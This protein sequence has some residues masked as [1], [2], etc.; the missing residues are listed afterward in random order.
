[1]NNDPRV[2]TL[3]LNMELTVAFLNIGGLIAMM[4]S[5]PSVWT[6]IGIYCWGAAQGILLLWWDRRLSN[7]MAACAMGVC[8]A[9]GSLA[10]LIGALIH[11]SY[12]GIFISCCYIASSSLQLLS[13]V[14]RLPAVS[15]HICVLIRKILARR[16]LIYVGVFQALAAMCFIILL[17]VA[18][19]FYSAAAFTGI[20]I[21]L[22]MLQHE[23][24]TQSA[25][26]QMQYNRN[27]MTDLFRFKK[28]ATISK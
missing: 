19:M 23:L 28:V 15:P 21:N 11:H 14:V 10:F 26:A 4:L 2:K 22:L 25:S 8:N 18:G 20:T 7:P 6:S 12:L 5:N 27:Q 1:M 16:M 3:Y 17:P 13:G 9:A 24:L